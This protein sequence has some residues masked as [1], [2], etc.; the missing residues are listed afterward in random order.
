MNVNSVRVDEWMVSILL[1]VLLWNGGGVLLTC[2]ASVCDPHLAHP[3]AVLIS[4]AVVSCTA[5]CQV[6]GV[7]MVS[8]C[9][10]CCVVGYPLSAPP[11]HWWWVGPSWMVGWHGEAGR[12]DE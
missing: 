9:L 8:V 1:D 3:S 5:H 7:W 4:T 12:H 10:W 6:C 2:T 11:S